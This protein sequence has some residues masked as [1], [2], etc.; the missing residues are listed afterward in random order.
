MDQK[1]TLHLG[2]WSR[3][4]LVAGDFGPTQTVKKRARTIVVKMDQ[5]FS[6]QTEHGTIAGE[7]GDYLATNHP[8][9]DPTSDVWPVSAERFNATYG[10]E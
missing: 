4:S 5:A 1:T 7:R 10:P 2:S 9:D 3:D 6:V 8:D